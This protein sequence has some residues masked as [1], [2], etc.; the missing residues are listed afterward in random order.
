MRRLAFF[1]ALL[2]LLA[3]LGAWAE[4][5]ANLLERGEFFLAKGSAYVPDAIRAL[6]QTAAID[7]QRA[8]A[9]VRFVLAISKAYI[10][11][12]RLSEAFL[13]LGRLE[14]SRVYDNRADAIKDNLLQESGVGRMHMKTK[15]PV[16]EFTGSLKV[17]P[18]GIKLDANG[19]KI[20]EK[21]NQFLAVPRTIGPEGLTLLIPEGLLI[22]T[23][24]ASIGAEG[25]TETTFEMWVGDELTQNLVAPFPSRNALTVTPGNRSVAFSWLPAGAEFRYRVVRTVEGRLPET[26]YEGTDT[27]FT[28]KGAIPGD[29]ATF[30][31]LTLDKEGALHGLLAVTAS[32]MPPVAQIDAQASFNQNL[33]I[34]LQWHMG[35]GSVDRFEI[36]KVERGEEKTVLVQRGSE[37]IK[38]AEL[39]DGPVRPAPQAHTVGYRLR[40]FV[41]GEDQPAE[42]EVSVLVPPEVARV[43]SVKDRITPNRVDVTWETFPPDAVAEGYAVYLLR[44]RSSV[45]E[46]VGRVKDAFA[47]EYSY[48]PKFY[49]TQARWTHMVLP[50]VGERILVDPLPVEASDEVPETAFSQRVRRIRKLPNFVL[51][52]APYK[53]TRRYIVRLGD[54]K[55]FIVKENYVEFSGL[56]SNVAE[57]VNDVK[58]YAL[59]NDGTTVL[60]VEMKLE[61][62]NYSNGSEEQEAE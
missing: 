50:Y 35:E 13:W 58:V 47:R 48:V 34:L 32:A 30:K 29:A 55:E 26:V 43:D 38:D 9:D 21:L 22:F 45:G 44:T 25:V 1:A 11:A 36:H 59:E 17:A 37:V 46:L 10:S 20:L 53:K 39:V 52:W 31:L 15:L 6:E 60:L 7:E 41:E 49:D 28:Y 4:D 24:S 2:V 51:T 54:K 42:T 61:Y 56:Q 62:K 19:K 5:Y 3:P 33:E 14:K 57:S 16:P 23:S 12:N 8:A 18:E 27:A 40:A